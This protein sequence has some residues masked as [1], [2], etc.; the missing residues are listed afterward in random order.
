M[1]LPSAEARVAD[2]ASPR[3]V[4]TCVRQWFHRSNW[5][6]AGSFLSGRVTSRVRRQDCETGMSG[7][8]AGKHRGLDAAR[9]EA[10]I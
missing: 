5:F 1:A 3:D 7:R 10:G 4:F 6:S 8:P 9:D 2:R